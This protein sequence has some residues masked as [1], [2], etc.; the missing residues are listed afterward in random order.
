MD[1]NSKKEKI[2]ET[3]KIAGLCI[4]VLLCM[5]ILAFVMF[6]VFKNINHKDVQT[7]AE[8]KTDDSAKEQ[9][10][11]EVLDLLNPETL[12]EQENTVEEDKKEENNLTEEEK[13]KLEE[14]RKKQEE[15]NKK[16]QALKYPYWIKVNCAANTVT[17][18]GKDA[19]NNYTVPIKAMV[20][21]VGSSTPRSGVYKTP[22]KARWGTLIGPVWGQYCT[23]ITG[24]ILFHSVPYIKKEDPSSLEYWEYDRLG[25]QRSLG[26]IRLTV[27]DAKWIYD[28]C[29]LGTSVEFYSDASNPG[30][31][32]KPG[33][34]RVTAAGDPYKGWDPTDPNPNNPWLHKAEIERQQKEEEERKAREEAERKAKEEA[35]RK[36]KEEAERKAREEEEKN[37]VV[38]PY[39]V[40]L[41]ETAAKNAL[42]D[43]TVEV[44]FSE[45]RNDGLVVSQ[46]LTKGTKVNKGTKIIITV[47]K[48]TSN[49]G[50]NVVSNTVTN[51]NTVINNN[52]V[53]NTISNNTI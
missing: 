52:Q 2:K 25:E 48:I 16:Q 53:G 14:Q 9:N 36:A 3:L 4:G 6:N 21:S 31:L 51:N 8:A 32:G 7:I 10:E 38:V 42:K 33:Y 22:Q 34:Q 40:G 12:D 26:C 45:D 17:I 23:R 47:N 28:N 46:S 24:Q 5:A 20:C 27:A 19:N 11:E 1:E 13:Q 44:R 39:V 18:Y 30:P 49:P 15:E 50:N 29:P 37:K 35:E 41:S 43:F